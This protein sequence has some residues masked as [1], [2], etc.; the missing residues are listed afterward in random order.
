MVL[1]IKTTKNIINECWDGLKSN[2]QYFIF[3]NPTEK[4]D[5][6]EKWVSLDSLKE[7][8][9]EQIDK[10]NVEFPGHL[11]NCQKGFSAAICLSD[12]KKELGR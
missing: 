7:W 11:P 4:Y 9:E 10:G 3:F 12:L 6:N 8:L 5:K 1:E 2:E